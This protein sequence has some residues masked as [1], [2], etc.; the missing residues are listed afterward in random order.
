M[1]FSETVDVLVEQILSTQ[2]LIE[3]KMVNPLKCQQFVHV[4]LG[5]TP[6][7]EQVPVGF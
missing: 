1:S 6:G 2:V 5:L 3:R 4:Q 7:P